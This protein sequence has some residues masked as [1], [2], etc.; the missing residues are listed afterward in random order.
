V[1]AVSGGDPSLEP[2]IGARAVLENDATD[3]DQRPDG[4]M[5]GLGGLNSGLPSP[6]TATSLRLAACRT[7]IKLLAHRQRRLACK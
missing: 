2:S 3:L 1:L 6:S 7:S 5:E 4:V